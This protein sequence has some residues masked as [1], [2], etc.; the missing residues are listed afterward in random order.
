V[1]VEIALVFAVIAVALYLFASA[2]LPLDIA[3]FLI[4]IT[5]IAIPQL[6]HSEW[7]LDRGIDLQAA[8]PT[9]SEGLSGLSSTATVTVLAMFIL[10]AGIQRSGLI[11]VLGRRLFPMVGGS[12]LRMILIIAALV[13]LI[14]GFINNTAAVAVAIPLILDMARRLKMQASR[15]LMPV[16]FFGMLGGTLTLIGVAPSRTP[17]PPRFFLVEAPTCRSAQFSSAIS[18]QFTATTYTRCGGSGGATPHAR[19]HNATFEEGDCVHCGIKVV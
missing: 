10:S 12:E 14:S 1:T 7:L 19:R 8:F 4:L 11:H 16:S 9:V 15:L 2:K 17:T 3:A 13:G 18:V 6:F 5:L